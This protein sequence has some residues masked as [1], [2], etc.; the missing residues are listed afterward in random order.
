MVVIVVACVVYAKLAILLWAAPEGGAGKYNAF[1]F[2]LTCMALWGVFFF[3][4]QSKFISMFGA[5]S[6]YFSSSP[7]GKHGSAQIGLGVKYA[8][9][10]HVGSIATGSGVCMAITVMRM[11]AE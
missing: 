5:A 8:C 3:S 1:G 6:Y 4:D 11:M 7:S 2:F 9:T 10:N